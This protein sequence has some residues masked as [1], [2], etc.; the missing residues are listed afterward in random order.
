MGKGTWG[1]Q[2]LAP[3][4]TPPQS[5]PTD[6]RGTYGWVHSVTETH[7]FWKQNPEGRRDKVISPAQ[8]SWTPDFGTTRLLMTCFLDSV[9]IDLEPRTPAG[10]TP[11]VGG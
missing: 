10:Q 2:K 8:L 9:N 6:G 5:L 11:G 7:C 4:V 3:R 1:L